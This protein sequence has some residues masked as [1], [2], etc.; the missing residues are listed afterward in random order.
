[1]KRT[2][3]KGLQERMKNRCCHCGTE[4]TEDINLVKVD[5]G[6][7]KNHG[8]NVHLKDCYACNDCIRKDKVVIL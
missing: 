4:E 8:Y 5:K 6:I 3:K 2:N 7:G 1:M